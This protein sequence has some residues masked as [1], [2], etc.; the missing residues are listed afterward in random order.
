MARFRLVWCYLY[1]TIEHTGPGCSLFLILWMTRNMFSR[2]TLFLVS[3]NILIFCRHITFQLFTKIKKAIIGQSRV[4]RMVFSQFLP[5]LSILEYMLLHNTNI[6]VAIAHILVGRNKLND[7]RGRS[8]KNQWGAKPSKVGV[9]KNG[10]Y[11]EIRSWHEVLFSHSGSN[12]PYS[13]VR[14]LLIFIANCLQ[15][16]QKA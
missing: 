10:C 3:W 9:V 13:I 6:N 11:H 12:T 1:E 4:Q 15:K 5:N 2:K 7:R 14:L 16:S 8:Y